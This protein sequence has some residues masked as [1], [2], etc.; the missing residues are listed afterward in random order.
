MPDA[1]SSPPD[2]PV[3]QVEIPRHVLMK[4]L[5]RHRR[6]EWWKGQGAPEHVIESERKLLDKALDDFAAWA[7]EH[8]PALFYSEKHPERRRDG[9]TADD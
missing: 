1:D 9:G 7:E 8:S 3:V 4:V 6:L 5:N 2:L